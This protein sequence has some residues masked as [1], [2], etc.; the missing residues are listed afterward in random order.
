[1]VGGGCG[2]C[3]RVLSVVRVGGEGWWVGLVVVVSGEWRWW[4]YVVNVRSCAYYTKRVATTR[5]GDVRAP[6]WHFECFQSHIR[7]A[8]NF[9]LEG[10][11]MS[12]ELRIMPHWTEGERQSQPRSYFG[13]AL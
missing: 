4:I 13:R 5:L 10:L 8:R 11:T 3:A 7:Y 2:G 12:V 1:M 6:S 9:V